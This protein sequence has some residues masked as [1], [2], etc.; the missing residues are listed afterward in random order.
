M[1]KFPDS[2]PK[3]C[4]SIGQ[5][6]N[7]KIYHGCEGNPSTQEDFTPF[8]SSSNPRKQKLAL[9]NPCNAS[10]IS[11]WISKEAAQHAQEIFQWAARWHIF[12]GDVSPN[13]GQLAHTPS[14]NQSE[15]YTFWCY[16]GVNLQSLFSLSWGPNEEFGK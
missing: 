8:A 10:G 12:V 13:E 14:S 5:A 15:H 6:V 3:G 4:P 2:F 1:P 11:C 9:Q 7:K 16:E